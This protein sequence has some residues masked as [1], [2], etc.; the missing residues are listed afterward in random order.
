MEFDAGYFKAEFF[1]GIHSYFDAIDRV[2]AKVSKLFVRRDDG[3]VDVKKDFA[4]V[5]L[6]DLED[7]IAARRHGGVNRFFEVRQQ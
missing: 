5:R 2:S 6:Y 1:H 4:D 3:G 7:F